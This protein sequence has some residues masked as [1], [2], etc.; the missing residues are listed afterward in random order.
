MFQTI[1]LR[2]G[3]YF[4]KVN[5]KLH[6]DFVRNV[7]LCS[8]DIANLYLGKVGLYTPVLLKIAKNEFDNDLLKNEGDIL[9]ELVPKLKQDSWSYFV[10][11]VLD[12]FQIQS[13]NGD[14]RP[15]C[16]VLE[17][18]PGF[19]DG[20]SIRKLSTGVDG[21]TLVWMWKRL[22][23][24]LS[25]VHHHGYVHGA[26]LPPH[27]MYWPDGSKKDERTHTL[28]LVDWAYA[29]NY[30]TQKKLIAWVPDYRDFYP[31]EVI[32]KSTIG[33]A[34]DL[35]MAA[36][37]MI[38]LAGGDVKTKKFPSRIPAQISAVIKKCLQDNYNKRPQS[39]GEYFDTFAATSV[40]VY[41][42]RKFHEF[43]LPI[44]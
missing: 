11:Q 19:F 1:H 42:P 29:L 37:T 43:K 2:E 28:R 40:D 22:L 10:P 30:K 33:P 6:F 23:G 7:G 12:S 25:W 44:G 5:G 13:T 15:W 8:G 4:K 32:K 27:V 17:F 3:V 26:V 20:E 9:K 16:N 21:R 36:A 18:F 24:L 14:Q 38:Y 31:P 39:M 41:G 34:T 35:Y